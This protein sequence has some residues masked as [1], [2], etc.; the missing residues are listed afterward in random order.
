MTVI[1][2]IIVAVIVTIFASFAFV[3]FWLLRW[4]MLGMSGL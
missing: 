3:A 4:A 2:R 1:E